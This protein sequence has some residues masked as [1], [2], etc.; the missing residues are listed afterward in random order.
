MS[1]TPFFR[2]G[3]L[4]FSTAANP[5]YEVK[6]SGYYRGIVDKVMFHPI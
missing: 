2:A 1:Y 5:N 6:S 4:T 3:F